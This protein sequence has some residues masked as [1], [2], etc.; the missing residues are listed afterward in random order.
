MRNAT[1]EY[2]A[3]GVLIIKVDRVPIARNLGKFTNILVS[4][5]IVNNDA[6]ADLAFVCGLA[7]SGFLLHGRMDEQARGKVKMRYAIYGIGGFGREIA[8]LAVEA[9]E[10]A[11]SNGTPGDGP[12]GALVVFVDDAIDRPE[13]VNGIPVIGFEELVSGDHQD[14][15]VVVAVGDG[16]TR[17]KIERKC[18]ASGLKIGNLFARTVRNLAANEIATGAVLC[19]GVIITANAKIGRGF[20]G[21]LNSYVAHDCVIGDY[22]TFAP[23][24][25]LNGNIHVGDYAYVGTGAIF[26]QGRPGKPLTI[27]EG[28]IVG[29]GAVVTKPVEPYTVVAGNP[30]KPIR[31]ITRQD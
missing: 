25:H 10:G 12:A 31:K 2:R 29:M 1:L 4:N 22:V 18:E 6:F 9:V 28:A 19:D 16:R 5:D 15:Q 14:R 26:T 23:G 17:E 21:N 30:A 24:V 7:R 27:G 13:E 8:P 11:R 20:Q 3:L